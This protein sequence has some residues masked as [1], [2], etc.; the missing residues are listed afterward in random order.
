MGIGR[1]TLVGLCAGRSPE[2]NAAM[3]GI[4]KAGGVYV[5]LDPEYPDGRLELMIRDTAAPAILASRATLGRL[6]PHLDR[7]EVVCID[8]DEPLL[9][10]ESPANPTVDGSALDLAYVMYTS[11]S[12]GTPKGVMVGH[13]AVDQLVR[14][15]NLCHFG[16]DEVFLQLAPISFDAS[17]SEIWGRTAQRR[18]TGHPHPAH[19]RWWGW[20]W[21]AAACCE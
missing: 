15:T 3:L 17:T 13:R 7:T 4:L 16:R 12:T 19:P 2:M 10:R 20:S 6:A 18:A 5:P 21:P 11:G 9:A 8:P 1:G 14:D